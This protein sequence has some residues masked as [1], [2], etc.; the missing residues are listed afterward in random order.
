MRA[1]TQEAAV[2]G[3]GESDPGSAGRTATGLAD[4]GVRGRVS[5]SFGFGPL[6]QQL[7]CCLPAPA[8]LGAC[9]RFS[10][11]LKEGSFPGP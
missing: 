7:S 1:Q 4:V 2:S 10:K 8:W 9:S 5:H 6:P 11:L 3:A